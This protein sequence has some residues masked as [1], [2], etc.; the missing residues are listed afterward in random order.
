VTAR[1][2][3]PLRLAPDPGAEIADDG[4]QEP[5]AVPAADIPEVATPGPLVAIEGD[6][7]E[8]HDDM[9]AAIMHALA[10]ARH[11]S[12]VMR[13]RDGGIVHGLMAG[14]PPSV[15]Q[16]CDY[17]KSR[18]WVPPGHDGGIT[19]T[20]GVIYHALIGRPAVAFFGACSAIFARPL[21]LGIAT[22]ILGVITVIM[23]VTF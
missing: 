23:L 11:Q 13:A 2:D 20:A 19:E 22:I 17:A 14:Q 5:E 16:Q 8:W 6:R 12:Q 3:F 7:M 9:R 1:L 18:A 15:Q 21:R 10:V 4:W